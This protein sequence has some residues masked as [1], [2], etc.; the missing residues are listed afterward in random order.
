MEGN[1]D[2]LADTLPVQKKAK[3]GGVAC[4]RICATVECENWI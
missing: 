2:I 1:K 3:M 4:Y